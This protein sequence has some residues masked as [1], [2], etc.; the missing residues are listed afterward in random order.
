MGTST[1]PLRKLWAVPLRKL[2]RRVDKRTGRRLARMA[3][4][5]DPVIDISDPY[6]DH[7]NYAIA[8]MLQRGNLYCFDHALRNLPSGA[9]FV[10]IGSFCGLS[11]NALTYYKRKLG[12]TNRFINCDCWEFPLAMRG[13]A[14]VTRETYAGFVRE[15]FLRSV[16]TFSSWDLPHTIEM[17]S[18]DFFAAWREARAV[19]DIFGRPI[20]LGGPISFAYIDGNHTY[21]FAKRDW[22]N[23]DRYLERGGF[24]FFD[25]SWDGSG[26][27]VCDLIPEVLDSEAYELVISNPNYLFRKR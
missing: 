17:F 26:W 11:T 25:D 20:T 8:G 7:L 18:D 15:S 22:Q 13:D 23:C 6:T 21:E 12:L 4:L 16:R 5:V 3:S 1:M 24:V 9:P 14:P 19:T 2:A 10:E 27:G